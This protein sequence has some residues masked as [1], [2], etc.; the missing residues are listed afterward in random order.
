MCFE[1]KTEYKTWV[2]NVFGDT[3]CKLYGTK[4]EGY[5]IQYK[6]CKKGIFYDFVDTIITVY[7]CHLWRKERHNP[8]L[9][10]CAFG[11]LAKCVYQSCRMKRHPMHDAVL[12]VWEHWS[13]RNTS[14]KQHAKKATTTF[15]ISKPCFGLQDI[16]LTN[17]LLVSRK[18]HLPMMS[19]HFGSRLTSHRWRRCSVG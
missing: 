3:F 6:T 16:C 7:K 19:T 11:A 5:N 15:S 12:L 18:R 10:V 4:A 13:C 2:W 17:N 1:Y 14:T 9:V 8:N